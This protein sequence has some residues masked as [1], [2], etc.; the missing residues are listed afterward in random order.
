M[1]GLNGKGPAGQGPMSGRG[2]GGCRPASPRNKTETPKDQL[3]KID[4][5]NLD[6][7]EI[8]VAA[9]PPQGL[10]RCGQPRGGCG[11]GRGGGRGRRREL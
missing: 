11:L 2:L 4:P 8:P 9:E 10:G 5:D 6:N 1:P 7:P 3:R